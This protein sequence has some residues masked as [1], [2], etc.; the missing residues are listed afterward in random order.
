M[1]DTFDVTAVDG[2]TMSFP[3]HDVSSGYAIEDIRGL[4][5]AKASLVSSSFALLPGAKFQ[6]SKREVRNIILTVKF[7][8]S[9]STFT[10]EDLRNKL[11]QYFMPESP[12][13]LR[14]VNTSGL[15]VEI[16]GVVETFEAPLFTKEPAAEI[17]IICHDPDLI[18]SDETK[19]SSVTT[20]TTTETLFD[21]EGTIPTGFRLALYVNRSITNFTL[22]H[23]TPSNQTYSLHLQRSLVAGDVVTINTVLGEKY[24]RLA[25]GLVLS[26]IVGSVSPQ[27]TWS[28][29]SYGENAVRVAVTGNPIP[30]DIFYT[31]RYGGL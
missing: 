9:H 7:M 5:P 22:Y 28:Q 12:V 24:A 6:S 25:S 31:N 13:S 1:L 17:S 2:R 29:F 3:I 16:D 15:S 23:R 30:Y 10:V 26:S 8:V 27:S 21:Y 20:S 11:Y 19:I 4:D 18:E 14:F